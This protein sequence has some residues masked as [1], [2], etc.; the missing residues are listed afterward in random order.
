MHQIFLED[1]KFI[2]NNAPPSILEIAAFTA[3]LSQPIITRFIF[4]HLS[5]S[6][7]PLD[8]HNYNDFVFLA[9]FVKSICS[10][11]YSGVRDK[12]IFPETMTLTR[13][14]YCLAITKCNCDF[15]IFFPLT[16]LIAAFTMHKLIHN[17]F[18][19][20]VCSPSRCFVTN[21][22]RTFVKDLSLVTSI[23]PIIF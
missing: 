14:N 20:C 10:V 21:R 6:F 13:P 23:T 17:C 3:R 5:Q 11:K 19:D 9:S 12:P 22:S 1:V 4:N 2:Q 18:L 15:F 8:K 16:I 7:L